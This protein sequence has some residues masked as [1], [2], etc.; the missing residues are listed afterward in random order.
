MRYFMNYIEN[1]K[2]EMIKKQ[3]SKKKN[4][5]KEIGRRSDFGV[6]RRFGNSKK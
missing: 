5:E 1:D 4:N 2:K 6:W 3:Y